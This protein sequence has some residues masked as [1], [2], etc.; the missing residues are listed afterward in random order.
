MSLAAKCQNI[1]E[2][3]E[4]DNAHIRVVGSNGPA[5]EGTSVTLE[6]AST[7]LSLVHFG[8]NTTTC[9][10]DGQWMPDPTTIQ[11]IGK[12]DK[13]AVVIVILVLPCVLSLINVN[14]HS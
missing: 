12:G 3:F 9:S 14:N 7:D 8:S 6:C 4:S 10:S 2:Y 11:C 1:R 13:P 5:I